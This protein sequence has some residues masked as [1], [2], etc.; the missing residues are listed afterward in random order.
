[1]MITLFHKNHTL[2]GVTLV[3]ARSGA[4]TRPASTQGHETSDLRWLHGVFGRH[5]RRGCGVGS[6]F[7]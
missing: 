2:V 4:G 6:P 1:M 3:D 7:Q 5:G